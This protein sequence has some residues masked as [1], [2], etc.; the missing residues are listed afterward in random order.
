MS[1]SNTAEATKQFWNTW[2]CDGQ[3]NYKLRA[4]LRYAKEPFIMHNLRQL[5]TRHGKIVEIG[6]GQ[7]T[8]AITAC[9]YLKPGSTYIGIDASKQS[10]KFAREAAE[11]MA[12]KLHV[13]PKFWEG[14]ALALPFDN[15]SV[16][17][18]YSMG[19]LHHIDNTQEAL[20][21]VHRALKPGGTCYIFLYRL[22]S[23]K[24]LSAYMLRGAQKVCDSILRQD[25][26]LLKCFENHSF[27]KVFG[28][29]LMEAFGVPVMHSYTSKDI[30]RLFSRFDKVSANPCGF[31]WPFDADYKKSNLT[32][33][34]FLGN[35]FFVTAVK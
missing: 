12:S 25:R 26:V 35:F 7:G 20:N 17:C 16:E 19:V 11:D 31:N 14:D 9:Q 21:E 27:E 29:M 13:H 1:S 6:C 4:R 34:N 2:P 23:P 28:T 3:S 33:R 24:I 5:A 18:I 22:V 8:D 10:I 30:R 32:G 15:N